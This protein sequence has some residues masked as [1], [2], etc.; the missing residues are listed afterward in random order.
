MTDLFVLGRFTSHSG[1]ELAYKIEC[2]ALSERELNLFAELIVTRLYKGW[3]FNRV[4]GVPK[5]Q[6]SGRDNGGILAQY[7]RRHTQ[8]KPSEFYQTLIVDDVL[9]TGRS[10]E[11]ARRRNIGRFSC[12]GAVIFARGPC[13]DWVRPLFTVHA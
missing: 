2:D 8:L 7:V 6:S 4:V 5:G 9:T 12:V 3:K 13:P 10:M 11:A 1:L